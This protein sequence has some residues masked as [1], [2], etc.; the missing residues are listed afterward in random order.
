VKAPAN[1]SPWNGKAVV[2]T[3]IHTTRLYAQIRP[4][5]LTQAVELYEAMALD[6]PSRY[7]GETRASCLSQTV[8]Y[9][10]YRNGLVVRIHG[11][12]QMRNEPRDDDEIECIATRNLIR[13]MDLAALRVTRF[14]Y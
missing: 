2:V 13:N 3:R 5:A 12:A 11:G 14:G 9:R 4:A 8:Q 6:V 10:A 1:R 7:R